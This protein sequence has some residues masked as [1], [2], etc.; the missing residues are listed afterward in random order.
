M[1]RVVRVRRSTVLDAPVDA[2]WRILRDFNGHDRWHPIVERS[3]LE[4][5]RRTDQAGAVRGFTIRSGERVREV[6][7]TL[8]DRERR[9]RYAI[10]ESDLP[11]RDYVAEMFLKPV[12]DGDR[13][14]WSWSSRFRT[15]P[16]EEEALARLVGEE[17]YEAG[18]AGVR[19]AL[20]LRPGPG[21]PTATPGPAPQ[22]AAGGGG[23][24][25][26]RPPNG[27]N[28]LR[29][30]PSPVASRPL[31]RDRRDREGRREPGAAGA[32]AGEAMVITRHGGPEV[33]RAAPSH[34]PPPGP[35]EVRIRQTAVGVNYIDVYCRTG[36]FDLV[37]PP[38]APGLEAAG[39]VIDAGSG[40]RH[41]APGQRVAYA[42]PPPGAYTTVRTMGAAL[43]VPLPDRIDDETAAAVLLK[44][45]SAEFLLHRVRALQAGETVL[46]F[47]PAGGVG[48]LLCQW[49]AHL[50]ARVIGATSTEAK[51]RA[52]RAAGAHE[53]I[54]PGEAS[55]EEQVMDLTGG[56]G[57]DVV[58]DGVGRDSFAHSVAALAVH[59]HLVSYGQASGDVGL[60]DVGALAAKS[61]TVS[62]PNFAHFTDTPEKVA[63]I[64]GRLFDALE[65]RVLRPEVG[66]RYPL[67]EAAAA[68]RALEAGETI[69]STVLIP[70]AAGG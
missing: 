52:A 39:T 47:A 58:Y 18:F 51:A 2:V 16:G 22:P 70:E 57:A 38:G 20:G 9:L 40:V 7:L 32:V 5:G 3:A 6:L 44:G 4:G 13:T 8:S 21:A 41:L 54:L 53:V 65:R 45:M 36:Y 25:A 61:A 19:A 10:V 23:A 37:P 66:A 31:D 26:E 14:F 55:L 29:P 27:I 35:G 34:A 24:N 68:H 59:G 64:T 60:F 30:T 46:V 56:R 69:G 17:V 12:T 43:V 49:A 63:A 48:R 1:S 28:G 42:C 67:R 62:R 15:P 11:L 50:G 33:F